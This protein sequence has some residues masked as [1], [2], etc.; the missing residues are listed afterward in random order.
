MI[1]VTGGNGYVAT[2]TLQ[3]LVN[4]TREAVVALVRSEEHFARMRGVGAL[5]VKGDVTEPQTLDA[6]FKGAD[7]VIHLA[8]VNRDRGRSTMQAVNAQGTINVVGAARRAGARHLVTV[9]GLGAD[10][11]KPYPLA[12]TQGLGVDYLVRSGLPYTV[13]EAS[14]IFGPGDEFVNTL[15]GLARVPPFMVVPGDGRTKFQPIAVQDVAS[16]VV[17]SL[18]DPAVLNRRLQVCGAQVLTLEEIIDTILAELKLRR[19]KVHVPVPLLR[20]LVGAMDRLLP[21]SP[22]TPSLLAQLGADN[23]ATDNA[24]QSVFGVQPLRLADGIAYVRQM[25]LG[26]LVRRSLGRADYR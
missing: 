16:C 10:A 20:V 8:A 17:R 22:V 4:T 25:R 19:V 5:P 21:K 24:T 9:V 14:V 7:K 2:C 13:L 1:V 15:A 23:V 11:A 26:T 12:R 6:A 18:D 3:Q